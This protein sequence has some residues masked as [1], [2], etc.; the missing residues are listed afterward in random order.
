VAVGPGVAGEEGL[1]LPGQPV[2]KREPRIK[3]ETS[4][5][6]GRKFTGSL[7]KRFNIPKDWHE[8]KR[9][10]KYPKLISS[11]P[12]NVHANKA[13][14]DFKIGASFKSLFPR[15]KSVPCSDG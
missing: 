12:F 1:L 11:F 9:M 6:M 4:I 7:L 8:I 10:L 14:M 15:T 5:T 3:N 13:G 2:R